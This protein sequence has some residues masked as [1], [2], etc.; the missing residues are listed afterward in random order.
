MS[1]N[2]MIPLKS[3]NKIKILVLEDNPMNQKLA[4]L[5]LADWDFTYDIFSNGKRALEAANFDTYDLILMDIQMPELDGYETTA[6]IR[7]KLKMK[8]PIIAMTAHAMPGEKEKCLKAGMT[9]YISKPIDEAELLSLINSHLL[10]NTL[11][12]QKI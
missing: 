5:M 12:T 4:G 10:S 6:Y 1:I 3:K 9:N 7:K 2:R 11:K 8:L